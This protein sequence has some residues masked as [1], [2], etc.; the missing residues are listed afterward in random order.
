[1]ANKLFTAMHRIEKKEKILRRGSSIIN[2]I[3]VTIHSVIKLVQLF[4]SPL[5]LFSSTSST[6]KKKKK[7]KKLFQIVGPRQDS[8]IPIFRFHNF[9]STKLRSLTKLRLFGE[10]RKLANFG[11]ASSF[12]AKSRYPIFQNNFRILDR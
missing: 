11:D 9:L 10:P 1:M 7:K 6:S 3:Y 5:Q 4:P 12:R 8:E 2:I